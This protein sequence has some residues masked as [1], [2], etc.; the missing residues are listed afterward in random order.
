MKLKNSLTV[1]MLL[2]NCIC[3]SVP[4]LWVIALFG[5]VSRLLR[6]ETIDSSMAVLSQVS[7]NIENTVYEA[8]SAMGLILSSGELEEI[9]G[10]EY[11]GEIEHTIVNNVK[12]RKFYYSVMK[13]F[14]NIDTD[15]LV[16]TSD[17]EVLCSS[18]A[19][20]TEELYRAEFLEE[21]R[22]HNGRFCWFPVDQEAYGIH[23]GTDLYGS[24]HMALGLGGY[25]KGE[26]RDAYV[27]LMINESVFA[28][29]FCR[30]D[31][32]GSV[33]YLVDEDGT[34]VSHIDKERIGHRIW[35][36]AERMSELKKRKI[37]FLDLPEEESCIVTSR[38]SNISWI[39]VEEIPYR[40]IFGDVT[41][42]R[43]LFIISLAVVLGCLTILWYV[44]LK[45]FISPVK[46]MQK[47]MAEV[48][49]GNLDVRINSRHKDEIGHLAAC[50]DRMTG[51]LQ[52]L[53]G[54]NEEHHRE[55][56]Q[57]EQESAV[58]RYKALESQINMHFLFHSLNGLKWLAAAQ[59]A[60]LVAENIGVLTHLLEASVK[61]KQD[62]ITVREEIQYLKDYIKIMSLRYMGK[63]Q[64]SYD[65]DPDMEECLVLKLIL[66]PIVENAFMHG[67]SA[68]GGKV[69][70]S[71]WREADEIVFCIADNGKGIEPERLEKIRS[72]KPLDDQEKF[73]SFGL[74]SVDR[75]IQIAYGD[76]YRFEI[77]SREEEGTEV[78]VRLPVT[79][80]EV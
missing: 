33:R 63:F 71:G 20:E 73:H 30:Q 70:I 52:R 24:G 19:E 4:M 61:L 16:L 49:N 79:M 55:L 32:N 53:L 68:E 64:C 50:F 48:E 45:R 51:N 80:Q 5:Y 44:I 75:R 13:N 38:I 36:S 46:Y 65:I 15:L 9:L 34:I 11:S 18:L 67:L 37:T 6:E 26:K 57:R 29:K 17:G 60:S 8:G 28:N 66:Q 7:T 43:R 74:Y 25:A 59:N 2:L 42:V 76:A 3:W 69:R 12:L 77:N 47:V 41:F 31:T 21:I 14:L 78:T 56:I 22:E 10:E 23:S 72:R 39:L 62:K 58:L 27:I 1:K 35:D 40:A 54:Q